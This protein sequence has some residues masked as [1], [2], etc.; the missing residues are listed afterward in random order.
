M[1]TRKKS[2]YSL[3]ELEKD[4]EPLSFGDLLR[5]QREDGE[6][7][8]AQCAKKLGITRQKICDFEK[9]RRL[10]SPKLVEKWAKKLGHPPEV[11]VQVVLQDQL[12]KEKVNMKVNIAS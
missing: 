7:T 2:K 9:G 4:F 8:Q 1:S 11:W 3:G 10:P 5:F 6:L 12:R